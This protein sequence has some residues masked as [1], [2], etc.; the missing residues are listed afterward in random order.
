LVARDGELSVLR[1]S[2][3]GCLAGTGGVTLISGPSG[4]GKTR[5]LDEFALLAADAGVRLLGAKATPAGRSAQLRVLGQL[6]AGAECA[7]A[8]TEPIGPLLERAAFSALL[9]GDDT[10]RR[11]P[12]MLDNLASVL[13]AKAAHQPLVISIDDAHFA[14][15]AS[16]QA[17]RYLAQG[18]SRD[19]VLI[20]VTES[21]S[22][23]HSFLWDELGEHPQC[24]M[25]RLAPL[26]PQ[27]V[28]SVLAAHGH[29]P[30]PGDAEA[31]LD[32][33]GGNLRLLSAL[34]EDEG[35]MRTGR[36]G[37][38][39]GTTF[40]YAVQASL[41]RGDPALLAL[42]KALAVL[43]EPVTPQLL[44]TL[45]GIDRD[46]VE[47]AIGAAADIGLLTGCRFRHQQAR[48]AVLEMTSLP[49]R[50]ALHKEAAELLYLDG[51]A[52]KA[53][54][55]HALAADHASAPWSGP[56]LRAAGAQALEDDQGFALDCLRLAG[57]G[58]A[59]EADRADIQSLTVRAKWRAD[60]ASAERDIGSLVEFARSGSLSADRALALTDYLAWL[61]R[62]SEAAEVL[63]LAGESAGGADA[64]MHSCAARLTWTYPGLKGAL[65]RYRGG[66]VSPPEAG[67]DIDVLTADLLNAVLAGR[68]TEE[69]LDDSWRTLRPAALTCATFK[70]IVTA[71]E[72]MVLV[73]CLGE[74]RQWCDG[75]LREAEERH[76]ATWRARLHAVQSMTWLRLGDLDQ[77]ERHATAALSCVSPKGLG[78]F[79]GGPLSVLLLVATRQGRY[80]VAVRHLMTAVPDAMFQSTVG[81]HYIHARGRYYLARA[82]YRAAIE[83]FEACGKLIGKWEISLPGLVPW[84]EG[85]AAAY[86][87]TG[88]ARTGQASPQEQPWPPR[89]PDD[90]RRLSDAE[91]KIASLAASGYTNRQ[92]A[93][94][95]YVTISTVEQHLTRVYRKLDVSRRAELTLI[96]FLPLKVV[97]VR[98]V[99]DTPISTDVVP[100]P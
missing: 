65:A 37:S 83:D 86:L 25:V 67:R 13:L 91:R 60:P 4:A 96:T 30:A 98:H 18:A 29:A 68:H 28:G 90:M 56:V 17:I 46:T 6:L 20:I 33:T 34:I 5:L 47:W 16:V 62:P 89:G 85:L 39:V 12:V 81:L 64:A 27:G 31:C 2:L 92:I 77:A 41:L 24:R 80:D 19:R 57:R 76:A 69:A 93:S 1:E 61:G 40:G 84:R 44:S 22:V 74:A 42:T 36:P 70:P 35:R 38:A 15:T 58:Q 75:L 7:P 95:L 50:A 3:A 99:C 11:A 54:A 45:L 43:E 87:A 26:G 32:I 79:I 14:D 55:R 66:R 10:A 72:T 51:A 48:A 82:S 71:L 21:S 73:G 9:H 78:I 8:Q 94:R 52:P 97:G 53:I 63:R 59:S 88:E 23:R 100:H 49:E